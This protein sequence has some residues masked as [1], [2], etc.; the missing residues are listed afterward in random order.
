V[1]AGGEYLCAMTPFQEFR[2]WARE[3]PPAGRTLT[4]IGGLVALVLLG[5]LLVPGGDENVAVTSG[6]G[7]GSGAPV[8]GTTDGAAAGAPSAGS[9]TSGGG[10]GG[11]TGTAGTSGAS[12]SAAT[13]G[14]PAGSAGAT[15]PG[16][17]ACRPPDGSGK[18]VTATEVHI[19]VALTE[20]VGPAANTLFGIPAPD[21]AKAD[22]EA[23]IAG[24]NKD[25]G[26]ACRKLVAQ[27]FNVNPTDES[28]M[29]A[30]CRA[31]ADANVFAVA[32]TGALAT[33]P[34][35]LACFGQRKLPYFG[36]Y[37]ITEPARQRYFP[38]LYSFY[39]K[40][41]LYKNTVFGL[42]EA[43]FFDPA[44]GFAKLGFLYRTC[45]QTSVDSFRQDLR[46][47]GVGDDKVVPYSV[48]C[49]T[50]FATPAD[51]QQAVLT[52]RRQGVTHVTTANFTGD[53]AKFT[54][55]AEQ[56]GFRPRYGVPD[57]ALLSVADG[58]DAP[59]PKNI[60]NALAITLTRQ[61]EEHTPGMTPTA[62]TQRCNAYFKAAG[63]PTVYEQP[64]NAGHACDQLW[65]IQAAL[66][67]APDFS[68]GS[69]VAGLQRTGSLDFSYPESPT[70]FTGK[71]VTTGGQ[72]WRSAQFLPSCSCWQVLQREFR[73][74][75]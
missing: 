30:S 55:L 33:K 40:E 8:A 28:A 54:Q 21:E 9:V 34:S 39:T 26:V 72:F 71:G 25:G 52:F 75:F 38:Y 45:E 5:G 23:A 6:A 58:N 12:S 32:D 68:P 41:Q 35:P 61:A 2:L 24:I 63:Q 43:G 47:A 36:A 22:Y 16:G 42:R 3:A 51:L 20:I 74:G 37:F 46:D 49:P 60:A 7:P 53:F 65:M 48:G 62:G 17:S 10:G 64:A 50:V 67:K 31:M 73:R 59:D 69:L 1:G 29:V 11:A 18:G 14:G 15:A 56:Q 44:K 57:E 13:S 66:A 19:A 4:A 70:D 27:Y